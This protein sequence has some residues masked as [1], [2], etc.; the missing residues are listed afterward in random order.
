MASFIASLDD[1]ALG[2][3]SADPVVYV[4]RSPG[5]LDVMGGIAD[6]SG[7]L[8]LQMPIAEACFVALQKNTAGEYRVESD[9]ADGSF[10]LPVAEL[11]ALGGYEDA[12]AL[13]QAKPGGDW[14]AY[15]LGCFVVLAQ[16]CGASFSEGCN[17]KVHSDVPISMGV[18]SSASVEVSSMQAIAAAFGVDI[19]SFATEREYNRG[20]KLAM[21]CQKVEN[22]VVGAPCGIMDQMASNLGEQN[23]LLA[24]L[25]RPAEVQGL[26]EIPEGVE[27]WGLDSGHKHAVG[28][29]AD[30][31]AD[32]GSVR[33]GAFMGKKI[34]N[35]TKGAERQVEYTTDLTPSTYEW[36]ESTDPLVTPIVDSLT[37]QAFV[38][39]YGSHDDAVTAIEPAREYAIRIPTQHPIYEHQRVQQFGELLGRPVTETTLGLLGELM[40]GSHISYTRCGLGSTSTDLLVQLV[41]EAGPAAGLYGAKITG[42]GSGG[43]VCVLSSAGGEAS[44]R[45]V[46]AAY[47]EKTGH[48][49]HIF[50]SSSI[51]GEAFGKRQSAAP[52]WIWR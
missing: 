48:T 10:V 35:A 46:A 17:I 13:F 50:R 21:L 45:A 7:A 36:V 23:K 47:A 29:H 22:L 52:C 8:V 34:W 26:V 31:G 40:R 38:D 9:N 6:Y 18:S 4:G 43:T 12:R 49:P 24:L 30:E 28:G 14:A 11:S 44:I 2:L 5:R 33:V 19:E 25:C 39:A 27:F 37:G 42:G 20:T 16:E 41:L 3:D 51:G 1:A 32:Y 15:V